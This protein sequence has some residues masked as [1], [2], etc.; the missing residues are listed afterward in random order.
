MSCR[1][2]ILTHRQPSKPIPARRRILYLIPGIVLLVLSLVFILLIVASLPIQIA[3]MRSQ[4]TRPPRK[5]LV[6]W[7]VAGA[8]I[9]WPLFNLAIA[10]GAISMIRLKSYQSAYT[11][12]I[13]SAIPL[14][15]PCSFWEFPSESGL[16]WC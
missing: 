7:S 6:R 15:S 1:I 8:L 2:S 5:D 12:A 13:L 4:S 3:R 16:S 9:S 11:A 10:L 14:C